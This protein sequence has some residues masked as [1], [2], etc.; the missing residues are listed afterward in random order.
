M[1]TLAQSL[2]ANPN[3]IFPLILCG[4][5]AAICVVIWIGCAVELLSPRR[6]RYAR[7]ARRV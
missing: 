4:T 3:L 5:V 2:A 7:R 1:N 6:N